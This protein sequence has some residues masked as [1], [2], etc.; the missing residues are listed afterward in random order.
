MANLTIQKTVNV[1]NISN[2][3]FSLI[4]QK[5]TRERVVPIFMICKIKIILLMRKK[6][7]LFS[8]NKIS[9]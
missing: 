7:Q 4:P 2:R 3:M 1:P 5:I 9:I 8:G 6:I